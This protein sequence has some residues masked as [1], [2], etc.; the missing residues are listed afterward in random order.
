ML[1]MCVRLYLLEVVLCHV[2]DDIVALLVLH[3]AASLFV[4]VEVVV[5]IHFTELHEVH[6]VDSV[7]P[8]SMAF[9]LWSASPACLSANTAR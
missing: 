9:M 8:G 3:V 6:L 1:S 5:V 2:V 4:R 7:A